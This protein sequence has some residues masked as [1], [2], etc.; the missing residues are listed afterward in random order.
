M[1]FVLYLLAQPKPAMPESVSDFSQGLMGAV[2]MALIIGMKSL[3]FPGNGSNG[4]ESIARKISGLTSAVLLCLVL[5][6]G[7][8]IAVVVGDGQTKRKQA[9]AELARWGAMEKQAQADYQKAKSEEESAKTTAKLVA[10]LDS[11]I[12]YF[13]K[14]NAR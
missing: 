12:K 13:Q 9:E 4:E 10:V 3:F 14:V 2:I 1:M 5:S 7:A 6:S 8:V 11:S